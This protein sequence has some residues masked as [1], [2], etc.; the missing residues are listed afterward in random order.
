M[1]TSRGALMEVVSARRNKFVYSGPQTTNYSA[2]NWSRSPRSTLDTSVA[3][4]T[5]AVIQR[6]R[7]RN[8]SA[9]ANI[10]PL[11]QTRSPRPQGREDLLLKEWRMYREMKIG[12]DLRGGPRDT[13]VIETG[14]GM[15]GSQRPPSASPTMMRSPRASRTRPATASAAEWGG[16][17]RWRS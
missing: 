8:P 5:M 7:R 9:Y 15:I 3:M 1:R 4:H 11:P 14:I 13:R 12:I 6:E 17:P 16:R 10:P 2:S